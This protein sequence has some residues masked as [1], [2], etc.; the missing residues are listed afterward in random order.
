MLRDWFIVNDKGLAN[1]GA[2]CF[3]NLEDILSC[4]E[5]FFVLKF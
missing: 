5:L 1:I 3:N 2:K 4:P